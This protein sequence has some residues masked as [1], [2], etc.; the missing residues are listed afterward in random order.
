MRKDDQDEVQLER[1]YKSEMGKCF[2]FY[3]QDDFENRY[4]NNRSRLIQ[5]RVHK[6]QR[7]LGV[8]NYLQKSSVPYGVHNTD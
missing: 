8:K 2:K 1:T 7:Q 5:G 4:N 3:D 6:K